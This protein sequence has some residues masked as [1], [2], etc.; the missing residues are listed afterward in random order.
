MA[1]TAFYRLLALASRVFLPLSLAVPPP[2]RDALS[3]GSYNVPAGPHF[4][5]R[6]DVALGMQMLQLRD[7]PTNA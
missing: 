4:Y 5:V 1:N 6:L 3:C 7:G 2:L